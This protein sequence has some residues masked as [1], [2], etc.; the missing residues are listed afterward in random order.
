MVTKNTDEVIESVVADREQA[1]KLARQAFNSSLTEEG[2]K[3]LK[4]RFPKKLVVDMTNE[5]EFK[6]ARKTRTERNGLTKAINDKRIAFNKDV[7]AVGDNLIVDID[8]I[9]SVV[10][11]PFEKEDHRRKEEALRL[12][13]EKQELLDKQII[14]INKIKYFVTDSIG[15]DSA[16]IQ[17]SIEAVDLIEPESFH[18]ELIHEVI[19]VKKETL[20][21]LTIN[22]NDS[23]ARETLATKTAELEAEREKMEENQRKVDQAA[24]IEAKINNLKM[25]PLNFFDKTS[26]EIGVKIEALSGYTVTSEVFGDRIAEVCSSI[27]ATVLQLTN[28]KKMKELEESQEAIKK[29]AEKNEVAKSLEFDSSIEFK[30]PETQ[31]ASEKIGDSYDEIEII[32]QGHVAVE[33]IPLIKKTSESETVREFLT[34]INSSKGYTVD[35]KSLIESVTEGCRIHTDPYIDMHRWYGIQTVVNEVEGVFIMFSAY[36]I[37]GDEGMSDMGLEYS[38][39]EMSIVQRKER[40]VIEVYYE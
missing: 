4:K 9:Y 10:V 2:L 13:R 24:K 38:L 39:D 16:Y 26:V 28:M 25:I 20:T 29:E 31:V 21:A 37:T 27:D 35:N 18:K 22:L 32:S 33:E 5:A 14:D 36:I 6:Q 15:K 40:T 7:K 19:D 3:S 30:E 34:R 17:G 8:A 23:I 1:K 11:T 12:E